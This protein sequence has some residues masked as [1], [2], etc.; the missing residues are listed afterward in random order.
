MNTT[1]RCRSSITM[2]FNFPIW[3]FVI[4]WGYHHDGIPITCMRKKMRIWYESQFC[5]KRDC[6]MWRPL[7]VGRCSRPT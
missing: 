6:S 4:D 1:W 7:L 2:C 5:E 3:Q